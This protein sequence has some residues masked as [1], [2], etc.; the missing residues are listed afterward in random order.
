[1]K[2][3]HNQ[4]SSCETEKIFNDC[5]LSF[6]KG[7]IKRV[8]D[9]YKD[10]ILNE[11]KVYDEYVPSNIENYK[12]RDYSKDKDDK[13]Q[14]IKLYTQKFENKDSVGRKYYNII[15]S[16]TSKCPICG[17]GPVCQLDHFIPKTMY[18]QLSI[19]PNNLIPICGFCNHEKNDT[20]KFKYDE[21]P[22]HPY[23][24]E[25]PETW[26]ECKI[27]FN[28]GTILNYE[29]YCGKNDSIYAKK[30]RSHL[31]AFNLEVTFCSFSAA[32]LDDI[33]S[34]HF[35]LLNMNVNGDELRKSIIE[36]KRSA[37]KNDTNGYK[38]VLYRAL[39]RQFDDYCAYL[40]NKNWD[41][42]PLFNE[43]NVG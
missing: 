23:F 2:R 3:I 7:E 18:P 12:L 17:Y 38:A 22:F 8:L 24:E 29:L 5:Y 42:R 10:S 28:V 39:L 31:S 40:L 21:I 25:M 34:M 37:E 30:Y 15:L 33:A 19:T 36:E 35:N 43:T 27:N 9:K 14:I 41:S 26:L 20:F 4:L 13:N 1:M 16:N 6:K 11:S 32:M